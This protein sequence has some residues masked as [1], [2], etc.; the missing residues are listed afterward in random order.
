MSLSRTE[1]TKHDGNHNNIHG[2]TL[3]DGIN[4]NS[5]G[6]Q[7]T[8][9]IGNFRNSIKEAIGDVET[10]SNNNIV[11]DV[12]IGRQSESTWILIVGAAGIIC[13]IVSTVFVC[14]WG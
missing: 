6:K 12:D 10:K 9:N 5:S 11:N 2:N 8:N 3:T 13:L 14:F 4:E 7:E 1:T